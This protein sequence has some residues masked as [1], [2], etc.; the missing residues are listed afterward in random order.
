MSASTRDR[1]SREKDYPRQV[2]RLVVAELLRAK[3]IDSIQASALDVLEDLLIRYMLELSRQSKQNAEI[4]RRGSINGMDVMVALQAQG[5]DWQQLESAR[6]SG[7][8]VD[9]AQGVSEFPVHKRVPQ[10][11]RYEE[12]R[13]RGGQEDENE[14]YVGAG[15]VIPGHFPALP[16]VH[17]FV[18][19][20]A[21]EKGEKGVAGQMRTV[22]EQKERIGEALVKVAGRVKDGGD[23]DGARE[24]KRDEKREEKREE[25]RDEKDEGGATAMDVDGA[26]DA[27]GGNGN[28]NDAAENDDGKKKNGDTDDTTTAKAGLTENPFLMPVKWED[29]KGNA[30]SDIVELLRIENAARLAME[31]KRARAAS[32]G[33][34]GADIRGGERDGGVV[35]KGDDGVD[36]RGFRWIAKSGARPPGIYDSGQGDLA[37]KIAVESLL[38]KNQGHEREAGDMGAEEVI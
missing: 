30:T 29:A 6:K 24:E 25:K 13:G 23:V 11:K 8:D 9:F 5:V 32:V 19:T 16:D 2:A 37:D 38:A 35:V 12:M 34:A 7:P 28:G 1:D 4:A 3:N 21:Y 20:D 17:A 26:M 15:T 22:V 31:R 36:F 27:A 33:H 10:T 14:K 18:A